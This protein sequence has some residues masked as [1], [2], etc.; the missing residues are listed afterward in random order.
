MKRF[1]SD[2]ELKDVPAWSDAQEVVMKVTV[3]KNKLYIF[4]MEFQF[5][6]W[7]LTS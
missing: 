1:S 5:I 4:P 6:F 2:N 3:L 7:C